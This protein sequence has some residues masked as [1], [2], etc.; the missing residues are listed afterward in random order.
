MVICNSSVFSLLITQQR[1]EFKQKSKLLIIFNIIFNANFSNSSPEPGFTFF[2]PLF[3]FQAS[4]KD[5]ARLHAAIHHR[6]IA[7]SSFRAKQEQS[8]PIGEDE[9]SSHSQLLNSDSEDEEDDEMKFC[10]SKMSGMI[11]SR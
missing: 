11:T 3:I 6:L 4:V 2:L 9:S 8:I 10:S 5:A 1:H 7:M